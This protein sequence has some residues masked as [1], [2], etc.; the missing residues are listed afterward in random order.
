MGNELDGIDPGHALLLEQENRLAF[1]LAENGDQHI[2]AGYFA[3]TRTL[4]VEDR[5]LQDT[6]EAQRRLRLALIIL[7]RNE[8]GGGIYEFQQIAAQAIDVG[9]AGSQHGG[10]RFIVQQRQQEVL[11][12]HEFMTLRPRL[13]EGEIQGDFELTIQHSFTS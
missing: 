2:G 9:A 13:L 5:A 11:N 7:L 4:H 1:L 10:G 12:G 3:L 6:L 8:W